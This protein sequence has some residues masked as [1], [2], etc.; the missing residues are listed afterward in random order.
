M[1][2]FLD[3]VLDS[4]NA[5]LWRGS[6]KVPLRPKTL[7]LLSYL[8]ERP[9]QLVTKA[10][11]LAAVW[12]DT[13]VSEWVLS[14]AVSELRDALGDDARQPRLIE[15]VHR[16]GYR[17]L[18]AVSADAT[19]AAKHTPSHTPLATAPSREE[20]SG[21]HLVGRHSEL[22]SLIGWWNRARAGERQAAFLVGE[23]GIGKTALVDELLGAFSGQ[24]LSARGQCI[25]QSGAGEPYL[26]VIEAL[27]RLCATPAGLPLIDLLRRH[28]PSWLVQLPGLLDPTECESLERR[29]GV[30]TGGRMLREMATFVAALPTPLIL[31]LEDLHWSDHPTIDLISTLAQ[32][33]DPAPLLLLGTFRPVELSVRNHPLRAVHQNL[34]AH[35][36][37]HELWLPPLNEVAIGEYLQS[38]WPGLSDVGALQH[39]GHQYSDGNALFLVNFGDY[40]E[41]T[42]T[43]APAEEGWQVQRDPATLAGTVPPGLRQLI[44]VQIERLDSAD[45]STLEACSVVGRA[46][47][48]ALVAAALDADLVDTDERLADLARSGVMVRADDSITWPDGTAAGVYRF[49]HSLYQSVFRDR[50]S[51]ARR[52]QMHQ[53]IA[54]RLERGY[55]GH[56]V[57]VSAELVFHFEAGGQAEG[58]IP[59]I[60]DA[61]GRALRRGANQAAASWLDRGLAI[62]DGLPRTAERD[63]RTIRLTV[64][65]GP[66]VPPARGVDDP[67]IER[68][69][70]QARRLCEELNDPIQLFQVLAASTGVY[71][72]RGDM[73]QAHEAAQQLGQL[74][75]TM[76]LPP[77][78]FVAN[79]F[80]G[81]VAYH[82][83]DGAE[84][85]QLLEK[86][87]A[88]DPI[89]LPALGPDLHVIALGYLAMALL[90]QGQPDQARLRLQ[91]AADRSLGRESPFERGFAAQVGCVIALTLR[92]MEGLAAS[93]EQAMVF[94]DFPPIAAV[95]RVSYGRALCARGEHDSGLTMMR[96]GIE[97]YRATGQR[98]ALPSLLAMLA[99]GYAGAGDLATAL[100]LVAD[101]HAATE[102]SGEIRY[103]VELMRLEGE[104][105]EAAGDRR[106]AERCLRQ[107][108]V[109]A[110]QHGEPWWRLR[111]TKDRARLAQTT[112]IGAT[113]HRRLRQELEGAL[114]EINAGTDLPDIQSAQ[115]VLASLR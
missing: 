51:P 115:E 83:G 94:D 108:A 98:P 88:I 53:R 10:D 13:A 5:Q 6:A 96:A 73:T 90:Q 69:Y 17:F 112:G 75:T 70:L 44:A 79:L 59:H 7:A 19:A 74:L 1:R 16:R 47:S 99:E 39:V 4:T 42:G 37:C 15:T 34:R 11:L 100:K 72:L 78:E 106:G 2:R 107:A 52:Q 109:M 40:L 18:P 48:A 43:V 71:I 113:T 8:I 49:D 114:A 27:G 12:P 104:L 41:A 110:R 97:A 54:A 105:H 111:A 21:P 67:R 65:L 101:G 57:E 84:A 35:G 30:S 55:A 3:Y 14:S 36:R 31:V 33:G 26:P 62:L 89:P 103:R 66:S 77:F 91:Q 46:F 28:A 81:M 22:E 60:E 23:A 56:T 76:P 87:A 93:G 86:A 9:S 25:E 68:L 38:R 50:V 95:G 29:L 24:G 61:G 92:D 58:A 102:S 80:M 32:R 64:T 20:R 45:R 63:L 82:S 85:R